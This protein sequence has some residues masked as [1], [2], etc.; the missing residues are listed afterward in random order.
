MASFT[1]EKPKVCHGNS[2]EFQI[3]SMCT[4]KEILLHSNLN[5]DF[6]N[7]PQHRETPHRVSVKMTGSLFF[8]MHLSPRG[9]LQRRVQFNGCGH[10]I[11]PSL[12]SRTLL[13]FLL[14]STCPTPPAYW[15][16]WQV[17]ITPPPFASQLFFYA[18]SHSDAPSP[19]LCLSLQRICDCWALTSITVF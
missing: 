5:S 2:E 1:G 17:L 9:T 13:N 19:L 10:S 8:F 14:A 4:S 15:S 12:R 11:V 3:R 18:V 7:A 16:S 6:I